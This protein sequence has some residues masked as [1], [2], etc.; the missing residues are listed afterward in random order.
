MGRGV[1]FCA[2][3]LLHRLHTVQVASADNVL[4]LDSQKALAVGK[5]SQ[6]PVPEIPVGAWPAGR[7]KASY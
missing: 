5:A 7:C 6:N 4:H 3:L 1:G 2:Y